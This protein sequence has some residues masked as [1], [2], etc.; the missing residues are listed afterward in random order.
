MAVNWSDIK[1]ALTD[2]VSYE[3][4]M[5]FQ[6]LAISLARERWPEIVA[7]EPKKDGGEDALSIDFEKDGARCRI[8]CSITAT[9]AK[10]KAD[11]KSIHDRGVSLDLLIFYT[12][13]SVSNTVVDGWKK[14]IRDEFHHDLIVIGRE[15][16][17][18]DL[19]KPENAW[20]CATFLRLNV[21]VL[22]AVEN[23]FQRAR[24]PDA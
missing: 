3:E 24:P 23:A 2:L 6:R 18:H 17:I 22:P 1:Q 20:L 10:I 8:A 4:G 14:D 16:I 12:A 15:D 19:L 13:R 9:F 21:P 7:T 5:R 11:A